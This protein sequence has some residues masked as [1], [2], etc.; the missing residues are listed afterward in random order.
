MDARTALSA[1]RD[2]GGIDT[3]KD[4]RAVEVLGVEIADRLREVQPD[5]IVCWTG[6]DE[7]VLAH[8]VAV[9]LGVPVLRGIEEMGLLTLEGARGLHRRAVLLAT[10]WD[11]RNPVDSLVGLV[12][13]QGLEPVAL[14]SLLEGTPPAESEVPVHVWEGA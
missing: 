1:I 3:A 14:A 4:P 12:R 9:R 8:V 5:V 6:D 13:N 2:E 11:R 7:S 10:R